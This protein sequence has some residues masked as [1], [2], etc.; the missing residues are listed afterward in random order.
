M[1]SRPVMRK[2]LS[3]ILYIV[4]GF[5]FYTVS[6][7]SFIDVAAFG[8][9]AA[10]SGAKWFLIVVFAVPALLALG[11]GL[12]IARFQDWRRDTGIVLL[13]AAGFTTFLIF[14]FASMAMNEEFRRLVK[15]ETFRLF[16][17]YVTGAAVIVGLAVAGALL[18]MTNRGR[19]RTVG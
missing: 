13:S 16:G 5:F 14:T 9:D 1:R 17:D 19:P 2:L 7:M 11:G 8:A 12:A 18:L 15:P 6:L 3:I 4:A 10:G